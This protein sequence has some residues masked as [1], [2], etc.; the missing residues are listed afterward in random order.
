MK[1][2]ANPQ[3]DTIAA[4]A[5]PPGRG[6]IAV[7]RVSGPDV[8][9][10]ARALLGE[11][12][13]PREA[14]Y[15]RFADAYGRSLDQGLAIYFEGPNSFTGEDVLEL[16]GHGGAVLVDT[17]LERLSGL[18]ARRARPGEFSERAYLND[19]LDLAQAEA[20]ADL[21][22][23]GSRAAARAALRSL[24]GEFSERVNAIR[25]ALIDLRVQL[26]AGIDFPDEQ[27]D[28]EQLNRIRARA[29]SLQR[30][31]DALLANAAQGRRLNEGL[32]VVI[33]GR[34]NAGKSTLLNRLVGAEAAI[35]TAVP[36]TTRDLLRETVAIGGV[37]M[38]LI[39]TAGLRERTPDPIEEEGMRRARR[40]I[41]EADHVLFLVDSREDP[42][43]EGFAQ[44]RAGLPA[45]VAVTLVMNKV[46]AVP[47]FA[48]PDVAGATHTLAISASQGTGLEAL[49]A[50]LASLA[51]P[52]DTTAGTFS[53]RARHVDALT[54]A[55]RHLSAARDQLVAP[56]L[57]LAAEDLR[58]AQHALGE[59]V[60]D[61]TSDE[62]LGEIF[63]R[64]CIGK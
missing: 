6:G 19:K 41:G 48:L 18:G 56:A 10:I 46:D 30:E 16:H 17:L 59:V 7:I 51:G 37:P 58:A 25:E 64:F 40:A 45:G 63:S 29:D 2:T 47:A 57:E 61:L 1:F 54:R 60:G 3:K 53:A 27:L 8:P 24:Q 36:G 26:E 42:R 33:A 5:T 14:R 11:L 34:P 21:I 15:A 62:L 44:E 50:H 52:P 12:P 23:A 35:V 43:A 4:C 22:D 20:V 31:L 38:E 49:R 39:D 28:L 32:T 13:R 9:A 55:T